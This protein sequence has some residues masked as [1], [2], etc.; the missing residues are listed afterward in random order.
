MKYTIFI[1][2][3]V[4]FFLAGCKQQEQ[5]LHIYQEEKTSTSPYTEKEQFIES[6]FYSWTQLWWLY[7]P[8]FI[9]WNK[10]IFSWSF[11][12]SL[13][14]NIT[15]N[16]YSSQL[17]PI[18]NLYYERISFLNE[19]QEKSFTMR[20]EKNTQSKLYTEKEICSVE[21]SDWYITKSEKTYTIQWINIYTYY[22][23]LMVSG[24]DFNP[25]KVIDTHFCFIYSWF[26]YNFSASN[27]PHTEMDQ[28]INSFTFFN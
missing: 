18:T 7:T 6:D 23:T 15:T 2:V 28:I 3:F 9:S 22:S 1:F 17:S 20:V 8:I 13:P 19:E 10:L 26:I 14:K 21:Y 4:I 24:P 16:I 5:T 25:F 27:F 12:F 11:S